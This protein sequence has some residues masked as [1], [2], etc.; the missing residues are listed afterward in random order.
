MSDF[1]TPTKP[2]KPI[3]RAIALRCI[4][5]GGPWI[6]GDRYLAFA[7]HQGVNVTYFDIMLGSEQRTV[8]DD[9]FVPENLAHW[10]LFS[11]TQQLRFGPGSRDHHLAY[12]SADRRAA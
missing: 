10:P 11:A 9:R 1:A 6:Y 3:K 4:A 2:D 7:G 8:P 5:G 12:P